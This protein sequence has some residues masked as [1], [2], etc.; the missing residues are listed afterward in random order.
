VAGL[1]ALD[2]PSEVAMVSFDL[3]QTR[4]TVAKILVLAALAAPCTGS[5]QPALDATANLEQQITALTKRDQAQF[6]INSPD[7]L[8][9]LTTL[10]LRY[11]EQEEHNLAAATISRARQVI[12][13]N[14]G[15]YTMEEAALIRQLMYTEEARGSVADAWDLE[16]EL[17]SLARRY[18]NDLRT[19]PILNEIAD[20]RIDLLERY[21]AGEFPPQMVLGCF[22]ETQDRCTAGSQRTAVHALLQDAQ[23][24]Y[25]DAI[26]V[27]SRHELYSSNE[28]H[29]MEMQLVRSIYRYGPDY[30]I[31]G[32]YRLGH[33]S[34]ERLAEYDVANSE[35]L[36]TQINSLVRS[37]D[38]DMLFSPN[39]K[40]QDSVLEAY[41]HL[42]DRLTAEGLAQ[43]SI[44]KIFLPQLPVVLPT[45][46]PN[47]LASVESP[48]SAGFIDAAFEISRYGGSSK[49]AILDTTTNA[50]RAAKSRLRQLIR[51]S[52]FRPR[53]SNGQVADSSAI[54]VRYYLND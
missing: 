19:A 45:F 27:I 16:Q 17:L 36:L 51:R 38:W 37:V 25:L 47:P 11:Q 7:L 18:P 14:Y 28:L 41:E 8:E 4:L 40:N 9:P 21:I 49:I 43:A 54:V 10:A 35:P 39:R 22:F 50:T 52:Q 42:H 2:Q 23:K 32:T 3:H 26:A 46:L 53:V 31:F 13:V 34:L 33:E 20:R 29:E 6:G 1:I 5:S 44:D 24:N 15:L 48:V 30:R 12:R